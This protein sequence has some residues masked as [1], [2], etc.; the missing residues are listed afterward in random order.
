MFYHQFAL[1]EK[2]PD[3]S[4]TAYVCDPAPK[5]DPRPA[6]IVCPGGGYGGLSPREAEPVVRR[7]LG[8]GFNC[9]LLTYS[10]GAPQRTT[11]ILRRYTFSASPQ[12]VTS[13]R[14]RVRSGTFPR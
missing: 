13:R 2:Y 9:Y 7:F 12:A 14:P 8:E 4:L 3:A 5:V 10:V 11:R 6:V 1:S